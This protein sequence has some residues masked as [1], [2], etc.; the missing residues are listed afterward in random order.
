MPA[1]GRRVYERVFYPGVTDPNEAKVV[2]LEEGAEATNIDIALGDS[3]AGY[4]VSGVIVDGETNQ[5]VSNV[6][7][8]LRRLSPGAPPMIG[9]VS[10]SN[11]R[12]EFR[13]ENISP[14]KYSIV[15]FQLPVADS[16]TDPVPLEVVDH[17]VTG[18]TVRISRAASISGSI[19][20]EGTSD[21]RTLAK[22]SQLRLQVYVRGEGNNNSAQFSSIGADGSFRVAGLQAGMANFALQAVDRSLLTGFVINRVERD[23][24]VSPRG[25]EIKSSEQIYGVKLF[26]T[27]GNG[28]V[29]GVVKFINGP[30]PANT[31]I[32]ARLVRSDGTSGPSLHA[33]EVDARGH[34]LIQGVPAGT[35]DL[36][37]AAMVPKSRRPPASVQTITVAD[38]VA[39]DV[40]VVIDL[41]PPPAPN[42]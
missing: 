13:F 11:G 23:G 3:L 40:E 16:R 29:R 15:T 36:R 30:P 22:L 35:Y 32:N 21:K 39:T 33:N 28:T 5:P 10:L 37:V 41:T 25:L 27:Y 18:L 14:G 19:V 8:G 31:S 12:G 2:E 6:R 42:Q 7:F 20:L 4:S 17:D 9:T 34:F 38:G 26:I 24:V 1:R